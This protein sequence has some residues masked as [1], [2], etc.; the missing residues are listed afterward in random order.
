[1]TMAAARRERADLSPAPAGGRVKV[2][3]VL[4]TLLPGGS[5]ISV[6]RLLAALDRRRYDFRVA[7]LRGE[8]V[9]APDFE[10]IDAPVVPMGP[11]ASFDPLC[12]LRLRRYVAR[13]A[14][15]IAQ[16]GDLLDEL[17]RV[18]PGAERR[19]RAWGI[20]R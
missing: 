2:L 18:I 9:L 13:R 1:M 8:P 10:A 14:Y 15:A 16:P 11:C 20:H 4:S 12:C 17:N 7:F 6:L 5:E 19:L 3:H